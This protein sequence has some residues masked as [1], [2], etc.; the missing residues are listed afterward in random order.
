MGADDLALTNDID[1]HAVRSAPI[2][3]TDYLTL[4]LRAGARRIDN[5]IE[6]CRTA[7]CGGVASAALP[8]ARCITAG[9]S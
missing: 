2:V 5:P 4:R 9:R 3:E 8:R 7:G 1:R 6:T